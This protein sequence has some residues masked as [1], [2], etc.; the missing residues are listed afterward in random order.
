[1]KYK[2]FVS[3]LVCS[4]KKHALHKDKNEET[5]KNIRTIIENNSIENE[6]IQTKILSLDLERNVEKSKF[7]NLFG[8]SIIVKNEEDQIIEELDLLTDLNIKMK[9]NNNLENK[10]LKFK[11]NIIS[12]EE[13]HNYVEEEIFMGEIED[14][15]FDPKKIHLKYIYDFNNLNLISRIE[16]K[17]KTFSLNI[18]EPSNETNVFKEL[19]INKYNK[20]ALPA[21][22][23]LSSYEPNIN[24]LD[25]FIYK[26]SH[27]KEN[28]ICQ[29]NLLF[30]T[31]LEFYAN[32]LS[33]EDFLKSFF[34]E[35]LDFDFKDEIESSFGI[36]ISK[37]LIMFDGLED[38]INLNNI[39][40]LKLRIPDQ[41]K[42]SIFIKI[43]LEEN[44]EL[45]EAIFI[46]RMSS[47]LSSLEYCEYYFMLNQDSE[48]ESTLMSF[49]QLNF[50]NILDFQVT[51]EKNIVLENTLKN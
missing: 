6:E 3:G 7:L 17:D 42:I 4:I 25:I 2:L 38:Y 30:S 24:L 19:I 20:K 11:S 12:V 10:F 22:T 48:S 50:G 29:K 35:H 47:I 15:I 27:S 28:L 33:K 43:E 45:N 36:K 13:I 14:T 16:Y 39:Q 18:P 41:E 31:D 21:A 8:L 5:L 49:N 32:N 1:M 37:I 51:K 44:F 23:I 46:N 26:F 40:K 34:L 9:I